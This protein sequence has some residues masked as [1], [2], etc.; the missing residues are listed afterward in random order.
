VTTE[1]ISDT[2]RHEYYYVF[3]GLPEERVGESM[4]KRNPRPRLRW[5]MEEKR[6]LAQKSG[7][8]DMVTGNASCGECGRSFPLDILQVDHKIPVSKGGTDRPGNLRLLCPT[9]NRKKGAKRT[10]EPSQSG[11][12]I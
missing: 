7:G 9:C 8:I 10:R 2:V 1:R 5:T 11:G 3:V 6:L 4:A 12:W